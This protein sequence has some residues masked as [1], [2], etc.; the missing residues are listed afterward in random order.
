M[1]FISKYIFWALTFLSVRGVYYTELFVF[2]AFLFLL[3][4]AVFLI[5]LSCSRMS[6]FS[7]SVF[8]ISG[9]ILYGFFV[10]GFISSYHTFSVDSLF[11][12]IFSNDWT[13]ILSFRC[14]IIIS[15]CHLSMYVKISAVRE[16]A[17]NH[18]ERSI[19][20]I[21]AY[22]VTSINICIQRYCSASTRMIGIIINIF[23][24]IKKK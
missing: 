12:L 21:G 10:L 19:A 1:S 24:N 4:S 23:L 6:A 17:T 3:S 7:L 15:F 18:V 2:R 13:N 14:S 8:L 11:F 16:W 20:H 5:L 22:S 9:E